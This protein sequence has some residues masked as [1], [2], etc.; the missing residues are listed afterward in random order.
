MSFVHMKNKQ[1]GVTYVYES[2]GFW[3]KQKQQARNRRKCIGK[4][5]PKSGEIIPSTKIDLYV[6]S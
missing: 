2:V 6:T 1:N 5:D 3:D 4:L